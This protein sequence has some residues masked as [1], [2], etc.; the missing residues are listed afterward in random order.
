MVVFPEVAINKPWEELKPKLKK[1]Y[2]ILF[3]DQIDLVSLN[4]KYKDKNN[5]VVPPPNMDA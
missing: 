1:T 3:V 4:L 5:S 2:S